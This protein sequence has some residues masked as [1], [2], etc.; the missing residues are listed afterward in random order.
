[1]VRWLLTGVVGQ[2][3][4]VGVWNLNGCHA[5]LL[6]ANCSVEEVS[7]VVGEVVGYDYEGPRV[8]GRCGDSSSLWD[9]VA[10]GPIVSA[11]GGWNATGG[12]NSDE[13][14]ELTEGSSE[15]TTATVYQCAM[16]CV[17]MRT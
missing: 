13:P 3:A 4:R 8:L 12:E 2:Y 6:A 10:L 5:D 15:K 16:S 14:S 7:L 11:C 17:K 9:S 1:M